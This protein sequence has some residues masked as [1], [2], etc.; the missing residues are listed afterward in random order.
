MPR[1]GIPVRTDLL[2]AL[3][4]QTNRTATQV[5]EQLAEAGI[6]LRPNSLGQ[7]EKGRRRPGP[8]LLDALCRVYGVARATVE[9]PTDPASRIADEIDRLTRLQ[10]RHRSDRQ[11]VAELQKQI[12]DLR[13]EA[14]A[15]DEAAALVGT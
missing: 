15:L 4:R 12:D 5:C 2:R 14:A 8:E 11:K 9:I 10:R 6:D 3:R 1:P 13:A 7:I